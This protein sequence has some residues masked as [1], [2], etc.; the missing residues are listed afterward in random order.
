MTRRSSARITFV[1]ACALAVA[2]TS[3]GDDVQ[4]AAP[5]KR[6][7]APDAGGGMPP[8]HP[9]VAPPVAP[10]A[11]TSAESRPSEGTV[12]PF[13]EEGGAKVKAPTQ[14]PKAIAI[15]GEI[16]L[17]PSI[18][19]PTPPYALFV[20]LVEGPTG[21]TP[22]LTKRID[23]PTFPC[24]FELRYGDNPT[25]A[26]VDPSK[27]LHLRSSISKT[28]DVMKATNRTTSAEPVKLGATDFKLVLNP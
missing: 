22:I 10:A 5:P 21:R 20:S 8:G 6:T 16:A 12:D 23:S 17:D 19:P 15:A 18:T 3:C 28:G 26:T 14:D 9:P 7:A 2:S 1:L 25:Q 11:G 24:R 4:M 27:A 13:A